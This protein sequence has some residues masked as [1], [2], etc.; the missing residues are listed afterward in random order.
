MSAHRH[1][2]VKL[3][4]SR[5]VFFSA[6]HYVCQLNTVGLDNAAL[7]N[8][9]VKERPLSPLTLSSTMYRLAS[10]IPLRDHFLFIFVEF[11][12]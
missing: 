6:V 10:Q 12:T 11:Q 3:F 7:V 2:H 9:A 5:F 1:N 4:V 8:R